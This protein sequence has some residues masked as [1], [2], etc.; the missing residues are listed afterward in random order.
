MASLGF[1]S[2]TPAR[3][4]KSPFGEPIESP[5]LKRLQSMRCKMSP[6][7]GTRNLVVDTDTPGTEIFVGDATGRV[8][9][10][11]ICKLETE[12]LVGLYKIRYQIGHRVTD[13]L[14]E[15]PPGQG[16]F[17]APIPELPILSAAPPL[18]ST[19]A[20]AEQA[21]QFAQALIGGPRIRRGAGAS[22]FVFVSA[23]LQP[24]SRPPP[25]LPGA[26]LTIHQFSGALVADLAD[27]DSAFGC[28]GSNFELDPGYYLLRA[29]VDTGPA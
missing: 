17:Y 25:R 15:L 2:S 7:E 6:S 18:L 24:D 12:L 19:S 13:A 9:E 10:R 14:I 8:V 11:G 21:T 22:L 3:C 27:A 23:D 5:Y 28:S 16:A 4:I 26:G 29:E 1:K 20:Q